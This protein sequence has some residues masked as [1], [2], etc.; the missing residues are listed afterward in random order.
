M[1]IAS[2][3]IDTMALTSEQLEYIINHLFLPPKLPQKA[4][5]G[6]GEKEAALLTCVYNAAEAYEHHLAGSAKKQ[7]V[8]IVN[9]LSKAKKIQHSGSFSMDRL[10]SAMVGMS[11]GDILVLHINAQNAGLVL[12]HME[13]EIIFESFEVSPTAEAVIGAKGKLRC[14]YP[15]PA[16]AIPLE[17]AKDRHFC[18]EF[19]SFV[20]QMD[21]DVLE[22]A[23]PTSKKARSAMIEERET[24]HPMFITQML[25][26][27]L[28]AIGRPAEVKRICKRIA[29]DVLWDNAKLPWRR[30]P[31]WLVL[32]V[33]LQTSL[34]CEYKAFMIFLM[35]DIL[36]YALDQE[37]PSDVLFVMNAKL[38]RRIHKLGSKTPDFVVR[39]ARLVVTAAKELLEKRWDAVQK[40]QSTPINWPPRGSD[41]E[42]DTILSLLNSKGY[43]TASMSHQHP[44]FTPEY[45]NPDH[46]QRIIDSLALHELPKKIKPNASGTE[47]YIALADFEYWVQNNLNQWLGE[48]LHRED[49]CQEIAD[50]ILDYA[51]AAKTAYESNPEGKSQMLLTTL[52][53]W[54]ALD[55]VALEKYPLMREYSPAIPRDLLEPLLLPKFRQMERLHQVEEYLRNRHASASLGNPSIFSNVVNCN[56]F[57][58]RH[59]STSLKHKELKKRI[60]DD[61]K[62]ERE[63]K[64]NE[65]ARENE[66]YHN[67]M[68]QYRAINQC[69]YWYHHERERYVHSYSCDKCYLKKKA[70]AITIQ[71]HEWPLPSD[72]QQSDVVVFEL[73][74]P[75]GFAIWRDTTFSVIYGICN[76]PETQKLTQRPFEILHTYSSLQSYAKKSYRLTLASTTKS[77]KST[78]YAYQNAPTTE[79][80]ICVNNGLKYNLFD[81]SGNKWVTDWTGKDTVRDRVQQMCTLELPSCPYQTLQYA[82]DSTLHTENHVLAN[83]CDCPNEFTM[84][85]YTAFGKLRAG[86]RLQWLN[87][88]RELVARTLTFSEEA[89]HILFMQAAWQA[90]PSEESNIL[91]QSHMYLADKEFGRRLLGV[92]DDF[93]TNTEANW[94]EGVTVKTLIN[95]AVRLASVATDESIATDAFRFLRRARDV[96]LGWTRQLRERL[97]ASESDN[98]IKSLQLRVMEVALICRTTYDVDHNLLQR[99][100]ESDDDVATL[101]ECAIVIYDNTPASIRDLPLT[102]RNLL[103]RD[104]RLSHSLETRLRSLICSRREGLDRSV[105]EIWSSY[106]PGS[107]WE[108]LPTRNERW[109]VTKTAGGDNK[110]S[111]QVNYNLLEGRL[112]VNGRPLGRLPPNFVGHP[113]YLRIF[114]SEKILDVIPASMPGM[115]FE[116]RQNIHGYSVFFAMRGK[117]LVIKTIRTTK[118]EF[119]DTELVRDTIEELIPFTEFVSDFPVHFVENFAHWLNLATGEVELRPLSQLWT[120]SEGNWRI[121]SLLEISS[122]RMQRGTEV[123]E[124]LFDFRSQTTSIITSVLEP[125]EHRDY[126]HISFVPSNRAVLVQLPRLKLD[127]FINDDGLL[128]CRQFRGM[129][130]DSDQCFG[131]MYGLLNRLVLC[132]N[133]SDK[134]HALR[135]VII[136]KGEIRFAKC[137]GH[138][139][140]RVNTKSQ[141]KVAYY[142]YRIDTN[143][144]R[145]VG[146]VDLT[147]RFYKA[148]LH[149]I[150]ANVLPDPLTGRTG[151]EE[152]LDDLRS[153]TSCSLQKL[154]SS[155]A[156]ILILLSS[157][158]PARVFYPN[159][160]EVMQQVEWSCLPATAQHDEFHTIATSIIEHA[161]RFHIFQDDQAKISFK[162]S[163]SNDNLLQRAAIRNGTFYTAEFGGLLPGTIEDKIYTARDCTSTSPDPREAKV[164]KIAGLVKS[165]SSKLDICTNLIEVFKKWECIRKP[166]EKPLKLG[167]NREWL[168]VVL[169]EEWCSLYDACRQGS[170]EEITYKLMFTLSTLAYRG[171][172][173]Q[174]IQTL[175]AF[176]TVAKFR[177]DRPP[178]IPTSGSYEFVLTDGFAPQLEKLRIIITSDADSFERSAESRLERNYRESE[179]EL[180]HRRHKKYKENLS[181]QSLSL[182]N[183]FISQWPCQTVSQPSSYASYPL[184]NIGKSMERVNREFRNWY[185]NK[186]FLEWTG[187]VQLVLDSI[188]SPNID[189]L[190]PYNFKPC[191]IPDVS[192]VAAIQLKELFEHREAPTIENTPSVLGIDHVHPNGEGES[193]SL[194]SNSRSDTL[195]S[196]LSDFGSESQSNFRK[197]YAKDMLESLNAFQNSTTSSNSQTNSCSLE[198]LVNYRDQC[199]RHVIEIFEI[200]RNALMPETAKGLLQELMNMAGLWPR[201]TPRLLLR[202]IASNQPTILGTPWKRVIT[203]Y[204]EAITNF[205]RS[206]RLLNLANRG[207]HAEFNKEL[208]N[209]GRQGW[210]VMTY[211]DWLLIEIEHNF[212][213]RPV[214]ANIASRMISPTSGKNTVMQLNMGEGKSSVI[215]PIVS[216]ALADGKKLVRVVILKPL[217]TQMFQLL[218]ERLS[219]LTN[220]RIFY[221]PFSRSIRLNVA[222]VQCIRNLYQECMESAGILL[223]QPEHLL[224]FKL[225][226]LERLCEDET[227]GKGLL[228]TQRWLEANSRDILDESDEILHVRYQLI[229]TIGQQR[230][231]EGHPDRW[232]IAQQIFGLVKKLVEAVDINAI[233]KRFPRGLEVL[234]NGPRSGSFPHIRVVDQ[235]A[236]EE[237]ISSIVNGICSDGLPEISFRHFRDDMR[238]L[239]RD[240]I[241]EVGLGEEQRKRFLEY[242]HENNVSR[243]G[244]LL[245]RGLIAHKIIFFVLK[246]KRWR[247]DYGLDP[248]RTM[249]AVPYRAKDVPALRA[250]FG[251]PDVA[252]ALTCLSYYYTGL[253]DNQLEICF[254]ILYSLDSRALDYEEWAYGCDDI[255][256]NFRQLSGVNLHDYEQ[257]SKHIFPQFRHNKSVIDFYLSRIVFPKEAKEF[258]TKLT[259]SAWDIAESKTHPTTGFSGTNDNRYLLPLP[260]TQCDLSEQSHTNAKVLCYLLQPENCYTCAKGS[261]EKRLNVHDL[262]KSLVEQNP[263]IQVLLDV[264][265]QV[266]ELQNQEVAKYWLSITPKSDAQAVL[267]FNESDELMVLSR[268]GSTESLM[269]SPFAKQMDQCLVYLDDAHTRG[270]DLKLPTNYRAAVTLGPKLTKDKLVQACMRMRKLGHGQSVMFCAPPEIHWN[271][272]KT[273]DKS[274]SAVVEVLDVLGWAMTETC[275]NAESIVALWANQGINYETRQNA[276]LKYCHGHED[277][278]SGGISAG[279]LLLNT[280]LEPE[281]QTLEQLYNSDHHGPLPS[282]QSSQSSI[283][284][285]FT[286]RISL[287][288]KEFNVSSLQGVR[289]QEEQEREV[290]H[291]VEREQKNERPPPTKALQHSVHEDVRR[292]IRTGILPNNKIAFTPAFDIFSETSAREYYESKAWSKASRHLLVTVDFKRTIEKKSD[293]CMDDFI[294]PVAWIIQ[295]TVEAHMLFVII[296]PYEAN[297]LI[298]EII[299]HRKVHLHM[300]S[301]KVTKGMRSF[302]DLNFYTIPSSPIPPPPPAESQIQLLN[303]FAGQLYLRNNDAYKDL[304]AFLGLYTDELQNGL[305]VKIH[306]D[307]FVAPD[308]RKQLNINSHFTKSPVEFLVELVG[309][310][311]K[312]QRYFPTHVGQILH[313][314]PLSKEDFEQ[315]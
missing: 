16:I 17:T 144:R 101:V 138:V 286:D 238:G 120:T 49:A 193:H 256:E 135:T 13:R 180:E 169:A 247:V 168:K 96:A 137:E 15:G 178:R 181:S 82:V 218:V 229:Y 92:L 2:Y 58:V 45:F 202:Q 242:C 210:D 232:T 121:K 50:C 4:D 301:P 293:D 241:S 62:Q 298:P 109:M 278:G 97:Q 134:K 114:G 182:A 47:I 113:T 239:A 163:G 262:L 157:L 143:L 217:S 315:Q 83:Q 162:K 299:Q 115:E 266:L 248:R 34:D 147:S 80:M 304:C 246:E 64:K 176:A 123:P 10:V 311:R 67:L 295:S 28:R 40:S 300:Y 88:A 43:L 122:L 268:D 235:K 211:P 41:R 26:E 170:K 51:D 130:V 199:E 23:M 53:L 309:L 291:E 95:L 215:V 140:V 71:V 312:G 154:K 196:L 111:L 78:H 119:K 209:T 313:N 27:I 14:S 264:G 72:A 103:H 75:M 257:R 307:G 303:I 172:G 285:S 131:T 54:V 87:M 195:R 100:L 38:T 226:G 8:S 173:L 289:V 272:L 57:A 261:D 149:A 133:I 186:Q 208:Q 21:R 245:L 240:F 35:T 66:R 283:F 9:M 273:A 205:Q 280:L 174:L 216:A 48:N 296:S 142:Q 302:E 297:A 252:I 310:R 185:N 259:T 159:H 258:P 118:G 11:C 263:R 98:D 63:R 20:E 189:I 161:K 230:P 314:R 136:P 288:L 187:S 250:E 306:S 237:L 190:L 30:S 267:F 198:I 292:F 5:E 46:P 77:F 68:A 90:G 91:R 223:V 112:L 255:P 37:T 221:M 107:G 233:Q 254:Q 125:L 213:I 24:A 110:H 42:N 104:R 197:K 287:T 249:L 128:E 132:Q 139:Q 160:L 212:L 183:H 31:F 76:A 153:A 61:A 39:K 253:S 129:V 152:A 22:E 165:W 269:I 201:I 155:E 191:R 188:P 279:R 192:P 260:I 231:Y 234:K 219:G 145:L 93:L 171:D 270:T 73:D 81:N 36:K 106:S 19:A 204:G 281:A 167:Y 203:S 52:Q 79:S 25:T 56:T 124:Q 166:S 271:I 146:N 60:E 85:E 214:Q 305:D 1:S 32:R 251:H 284:P 175:L 220:R 29:D 89:V 127:F 184:L 244:M 117:Q 158:T 206:E 3:K 84:H 44:D 177:S 308:G 194:L 290:A 126:I 228:D 200:I 33:A 277:A 69:D 156:E 179:N 236:G 141:K 86:H 276:W 7:W 6:V 227:V 164:F 151:T 148:Y 102:M 99:V 294:R 207:D 274:S 265:A 243:L 74:C 18:E 225:M 275:I 55:K 94:L 116:T 65:L 224:S 150:T 12:R 59:F 222:Q 105:R 70:A 108:A 282:T